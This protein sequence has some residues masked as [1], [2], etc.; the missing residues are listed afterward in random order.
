VLDGEGV[1]EIGQLVTPIGPGT[2]LFIPPHAPHRT[3]NTGSRPLRFLW[4]FPTDSVGEISY[5]YDE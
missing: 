1:S 4:V 3:R 2:A 5:H